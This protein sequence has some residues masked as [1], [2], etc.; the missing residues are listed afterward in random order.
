MR[1]RLA[2]EAVMA[3]AL[4]IAMAVGGTAKA[5]NDTPARVS[6]AKLEPGIHKIRHV[7]IITQE[8]RSFD[9]YF[10]TF[11]GADGIKPG[12]CLPDPSKGRCQ[13]PWPDHH[14]ANGNNPHG[15]TPFIGDYNH[16]K[17]NGF[18]AVAD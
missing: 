1:S 11:P 9:N 12:T 2:A 3:V 17:M 18:V 7:I 15:V 14:D 10:G 16:G 13:K 6:L 5:G 4:G 8:N